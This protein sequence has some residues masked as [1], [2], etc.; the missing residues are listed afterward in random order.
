MIMSSKTM[1][2]EL[3]MFWRLCFEANIAIREGVSC[4]LDEIRDEMET[5]AM[6]TDWPMLRARCVDV[7]AKIDNLPLVAS[8]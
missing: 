8:A 1:R 2:N 4:D 6:M 3:N 5:L 7:V